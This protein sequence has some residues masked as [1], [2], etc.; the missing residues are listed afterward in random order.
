MIKSN[1]INIGIKESF[2]EDKMGC[3]SQV[4]LDDNLVFS[5]T[6]HD[7]STGI[8]TDADAPPE[9]RIYEDETATAILTGSMAKLDDGNTTG[10]YTELI[11]CTSANGFE[12]GKGYTIY[13]YGSVDGN[14]GG[15]SLGFR[16]SKNQFTSDGWLKT[17]QQY[18]TGEVV[19]D[20]SNG[21]LTFKTNLSEAT[22]DAHKGKY[23]KFTD[24]TLVNQVKKVSAYNGTTKFITVTSSFTGTPTAADPFELIDQ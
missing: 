16:V 11:A 2:L 21:G 1:G 6:T 24:G 13:I 9:Y 14:E 7:A 3:P 8:L 19:A 22:N 4:E 12:R 20:G 17:D 10:F 15:L 5:V 23:L 18:P